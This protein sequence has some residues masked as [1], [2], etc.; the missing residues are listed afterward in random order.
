MKV[1]IIIRTL[2]E[3]KDIKSCLDALKAQS[4]KPDMVMVVDNLSQDRTIEIV[5]AFKDPFIKTKILHNPVIGYSTG[6]NLGIEN[7][8]TPFLVFLS[9]DCIPKKDWLK[10][11]LRVQSLTNSDVV[12]GSEILPNLQTNYIH[13]VLNSQKD[14]SPRF[15][16]IKYFNNT[17][18][19]YR[20]DTLKKYGPFKGESG[21]EDVRMS[22]AYSN[23]NKYAHFA[24]NAI[25]VHDK[26][27]NLD[28]FKSRIRQHGKVSLQLLTEYPFRPRLYLNP[29]YWSFIEFVKGVKMKDRAYIKISVTRLSST[30]RGI[31]EAKKT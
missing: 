2:N 19:L 12:Q 14:S 11:L 1:T 3:E 25:V 13:K 8:K 18:T 16:R 21:A 23:N 29:F 31:I 28:E 17:N 27:K 26:F 6:L 5:K 30:I 9:A 22:I 24:S 10:E 20:L 7:A 15:S 4:L